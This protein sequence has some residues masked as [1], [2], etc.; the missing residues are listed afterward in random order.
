MSKKIGKI[1]IAITVLGFGASPAY[2]GIHIEP[3]VGY[4][5]GKIDDGTTK[6]DVSGMGYGARLGWNTL[7]LMY[8]GEFQSGKLK[9][10][11]TPT[12]TDMTPTDMGVFVGFNF[13]IL[14]RVYGT[15]FFSSTVSTS[16]GGT[17]S[18]VKDGSGMKL[19][20]GYTGLPFLAINFE[21]YN[22][23][24]SKAESGGTTSDLNPKFKANTY[25]LNISLP[26][27]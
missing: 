21:M 16:S 18:K 22:S 8:G 11:T 4:V 6:D 1:L 26:L 23:E 17:S 19:G 13:P 5:S 27:P 15:Y 14:L 25:M 9:A 12:S 7:G 24:Y 3:Y 20:V 10:K 2:A